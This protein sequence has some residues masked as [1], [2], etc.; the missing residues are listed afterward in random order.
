MK[1]LNFVGLKLYNEHWTKLCNFIADEHRDLISMDKC[2]ENN[3][4]RFCEFETH[5]T[6]MYNDSYKYG[7]NV[8]E[9]KLLIDNAVKLNFKHLTETHKVTLPKVIIDTFDN[10]D[11][12]ILKLN[13]LNISCY[14]DCKAIHDYLESNCEHPSDYVDYNPHLTLTY[15][16]PDISDEEIQDLIEDIKVNC[17]V[18]EVLTQ[19]EVE[20]LMLSNRDEEISKIIKFESSK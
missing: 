4:A 7:P 19:F 9:I 11:A 12:Q 20:G 2:Q 10:P 16:R 17:D 8:T 5:I 6:L 1:T 18:D 3:L 15:L 14:E 13:A